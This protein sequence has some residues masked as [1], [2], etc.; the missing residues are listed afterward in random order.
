MAPAKPL[1]EYNVLEYVG[2][3]RVADNECYPW[4]GPRRS[5]ALV[6]VIE[7]CCGCLCFRETRV[8]L[9]DAAK[10]DTALADQV[11]GTGPAL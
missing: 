3:H 2:D 5:V 6:V 11:E 7:C 1:G 4:F 9:L 10:V 8:I